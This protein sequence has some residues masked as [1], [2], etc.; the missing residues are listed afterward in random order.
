M[1]TTLFT[2]QIFT[3]LFSLQ[4]I[5]KA[6][7]PCGMVNSIVQNPTFEQLNFTPD[8]PSQLNAA[9]HWSQASAKGTTDFIDLL[10]VNTSPKIGS[11]SA[12]PNGSSHFVG[13]QAFKNRRR[14]SHFEY[15][16]TCLELEDTTKYT[17]KAYVGAP[18]GNPNAYPNEEGFAAGFSGELVIMGLTHCR[19]PLK[20]RDCKE[21]D[22]F[23]E[24]ARIYVSIPA[25]RWLPE[26]IHT[27]FTTTQNIKSVIVG[28][29]CS[30]S[31]RS[32]ILID[33]I[34]IAKGNLCPPPT[35]QVTSPP[36]TT[37]QG[38]SIEALLDDL[39]KN[40]KIRKAKRRKEKGKPYDKYLLGESEVQAE[41]LETTD[42][43]IVEV[44]IDTTYLD[45]VLE[46]VR[47]EPAELS[48][49]YFDFNEE[50]LVEK[51][52]SKL[53]ILI[54]LWREDRART[55]VLSAYADPKGSDE[56][57]LKLSERRLNSV[58]NYLIKEGIPEGRISSDYKGENYL[59]ED[60]PD[61]KK[62]TVHISM[63]E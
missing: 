32:Y 11:V 55:I 50:E 54:K 21:N 17:F 18:A 43:I 34:F 30:I 28:P 63:Y 13:I 8:R 9:K 40:R 15:L 19:F 27:T 56:Y 23:V 51:E 41:I 48:N 12:P 47:I 45:T 14:E 49:V 46:E 7:D 3:L 29:S 16:G 57:N 2:V 20:G 44:M 5:A 52:F 53:D 4:T 33:D 25:G 1:K 39:N 58:K 36:I 38:P 42:T 26:K 37:P 22:G 61:W 24:L 62:R 10:N 31:K 6:Q 60:D 59:D 35:S